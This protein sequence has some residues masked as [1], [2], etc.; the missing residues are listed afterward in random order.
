MGKRYLMD[1][2][3]LIEFVGN[4]LPK[5]AHKLIVNIIDNDFNLSF[6][7]KIEVLGHK[8]ADDSWLK[9][10]N[11]ATIIAANDDIIEQTILIRKTNK[12]KLPDALIAATALV[13][14][15]ILLTRNSSDFKSIENLKLENPWLWE[16]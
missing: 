1:S 14:D 3:V 5:E 7:N 4:L 6:I 16:A 12:I 13:N 10:I 2:N 8:L 15:L 9:F 11:Q